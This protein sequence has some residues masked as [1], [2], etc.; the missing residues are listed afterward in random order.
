MN[1]LEK[2][3]VLPGEDSDDLRDKHE[4]EVSPATTA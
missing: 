2:S 4:G 1:C 3:I